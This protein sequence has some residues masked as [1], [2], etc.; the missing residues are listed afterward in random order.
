M[1][2]PER[3]D[4]RTAKVLTGRLDPYRE[5]VNAAGER[6]GLVVLAAAPWSG[7]SAMLELLAPQLDEPAL[8]VDAR[9]CSGA[10]DLALAIAERAVA[11]YMPEA[12]G[13]WHG[14]APASAT[15]GLLLWRRLRAAGLDPDALR[16]DDAPGPRRLAGALELVDVLADA[17]PIVIIDHLGRM[18]AAMRPA[19]GRAILETLRAARQR[20]DRID[21]WLV[22]H[23]AGPIERALADPE[24]PLYRAGAALAIHRPTPDLFAIEVPVAWPDDDHP[25]RTLMRMAA[26]VCAGVPELT[27]QVA[28]LAMAHRGDDSERALMGWRELRRLTEGQVRRQW[29]L[30][31]RVHPSALDVVAELSVGRAPHAAPGASKSI[32]DAL[33]RLRDVGYAW[34]PVP[35]T[36]ALSDPLLA[37]WARENPM[38][39]TIAA[40]AYAA[41]HSRR[42]SVR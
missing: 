4:E 27:W 23:P 2:A 42:P 38:P 25:P 34:Q 31:R 8:L 29:D 9:V 36:W 33:G 13:W 28:E 1:T 10:G 39:H 11:Q 21:V 32:N 24:H 3:D 19:E 14:T 30:L 22:D 35:R 17:K 20:L 16:E 37:A 6:Y 12:L 26:D 41:A 18:L 5:L 7:T 15:S 40:S